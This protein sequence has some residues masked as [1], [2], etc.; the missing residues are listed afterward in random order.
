LCT[1]REVSVVDKEGIEENLKVIWIRVIGSEGLDHIF[2]RIEDGF[3]SEK[4]PFIVTNKPAKSD[5]KE[6]RNDGF[7]L[8]SGLFFGKVDNG[9]G[10]QG[11]NLLENLDVMSHI[12]LN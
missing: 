9:I 6:F 7:L 12:I 5:K 8:W 11:D 3:F 10:H 4:N 2:N 1:K